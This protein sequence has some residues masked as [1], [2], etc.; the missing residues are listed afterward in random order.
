MR[1]TREKDA[2][3]GVGEGEGGGEA[4]SAKKSRKAATPGKRSKEGNL[5]QAR[6]ED[7]VGELAAAN[8]P[9]SSGVKPEPG[10]PL[11]KHEVPP[12]KPE[13]YVYPPLRALLPANE[14]H[15]ANLLWMSKFKESF[16]SPLPLADQGQTADRVDPKPSGALPA[17]VNAIRLP[18]VQIQRRLNPE[19]KASGRVAKEEGGESDDGTTHTRAKA[20]PAFG[21]NG[22]PSVGGEGTEEEPIPPKKASGKASPGCPVGAKVYT[23][24]VHPLQLLEPLTSASGKRLTKFLWQHT[25]ERTKVELLRSATARGSG[26]ESSKRE[27]TVRSATLPGADPKPPTVSKPTPEAEA[28]E[29][30]ISENPTL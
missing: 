27:A 11:P 5:V 7:V 3:A 8:H 13:E 17:C 9:P 14:Q 18:L 24:M 16:E 20:N 10:A 30:P 28:T 19:K 25:S 4:P 26:G 1:R 22:A 6:L 12:P 15:R 23:L 29:A 21:E 2:L